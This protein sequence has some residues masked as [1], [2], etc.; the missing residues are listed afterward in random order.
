[1][2]SFF[3]LQDR[4]LQQRVYYEAVPTVPLQEEP[5]VDGRR[6]AQ[7]P[8]RDPLHVVGLLRRLARQQHRRCGEEGRKRQEVIK[9]V[10]MTRVYIETRSHT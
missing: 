5:R 1:M 4:R 6:D 8:A 2:L 3:Q 9:N 10:A 7:D